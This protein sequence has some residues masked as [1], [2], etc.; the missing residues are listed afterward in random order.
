MHVSETR[1]F[2]TDSSNNDSF[3]AAEFWK[4]RMAKRPDLTG[5]GTSALPL[6]WQ[7]WMY[8]GKKRAYRKILN[9]AGFSISGAS[10]LDFGCG[11]GY[12]E[13]VW[14]DWGAKQADGIDIVPSNIDA[15]KASHPDRSY[16]C[17]D[18]GSEPEKIADLPEY[19]LV[20]AIDVVYHIVEDEPFAIT[21]EALANRIKL[22]G[23]L[24]LTDGMKDFSP[25]AHVQ[26]RSVETWERELACVGLTLQHRRPVFAR[27]NRATKF[28]RKWPRI[29]GAVN[30][31]LDG[32]S[33][34]EAEVNNW[35]AL[36]RKEAK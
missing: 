32:L 20:T 19:D 11:T 13:D 31:W 18:L 22:G 27:N 29:A 35:V 5:T 28:A 25:A 14:L 16:V 15:L 6:S 2:M 8:R 9:E 23:W 36:A 30:H 12:F 21:L 17:A 7:K 3:D 26:F 34:K 33:M 24:L 10:V 1:M 4:R